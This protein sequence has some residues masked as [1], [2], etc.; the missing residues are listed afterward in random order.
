MIF[1]DM[2]CHNVETQVNRVDS[3]E[4]Q[5]AEQTTV[6]VRPGVTAQQKK[7]EQ[8]VKENIINTKKN[9]ISVANQQK[10]GLVGMSGPELNRDRFTGT[11]YG[12]RRQPHIRDKHIFAV[13]RPNPATRPMPASKR[14][15]L[16]AKKD[17]MAKAVAQR[18][19]IQPSVRP[20]PSSAFNQS[21]KTSDNRKLTSGLKSSGSHYNSKHKNKLNYILN[22]SPSTSGYRSGA[23]NTS[24]HNKDKRKLSEMSDRRKDSHHSSKQK[25]KVYVSSDESRS[26]IDFNCESNHK[27]KEK[28]KRKRSESPEFRTT[29]NQSSKQKNKYSLSSDDSRSS[30]PE[31]D[32]SRHKTKEKMKRKLIESSE[33][34][35]TSSSKQ[36]KKLIISSDESRSSSPERD[37][38]SKHKTTNKKM[39]TTITRAESE[40]DTEVPNQ[41][42]KSSKF[43]CFFCDDELDDYQSAA[44]HLEAHLPEIVEHTDDVRMSKPVHKWFSTFLHKQMELFKRCPIRVRAIR[45]SAVLFVSVSL[46]SNV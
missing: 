4:E 37:D 21:N 22:G 18:N 11:S 3:T 23:N 32:D 26:P 14:K 45:L 15:E 29:T 1:K 9:Y 31:R 39:T 8:Y 41:S 6:S 28:S 33:L 40:S 46:K 20:K 10:H 7:Q 5:S 19:A 25:N 30:S 16:M 24:V 42:N 27:N 17:L 35:S 2:F 38:N 44:A 36:K 12:P 34:R 43:V 13:K